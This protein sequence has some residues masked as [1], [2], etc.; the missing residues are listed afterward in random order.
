MA[1]GIITWFHPWAY[2]ELFLAKT[3]QTYLSLILSWMTSN[4][5]LPVMLLFLDKRK[6]GKKW[7]K[8]TSIAGCG[9]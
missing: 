9:F 1:W 8:T 4:G 6:P 3:N 2:E 7:R 5:T